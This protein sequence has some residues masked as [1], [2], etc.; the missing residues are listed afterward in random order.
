MVQ[1]QSAPELT[2]SQSTKDM[3]LRIKAKRGIHVWFKGILSPAFAEHT[4]NVVAAKQITYKW[5]TLCESSKNCFASSAEMS[6]T[7][8]VSYTH[9]TL[10]TKRIV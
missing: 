5:V 9:L 3:E 2:H 1:S 6:T 4:G 7:K 10:P 8:T